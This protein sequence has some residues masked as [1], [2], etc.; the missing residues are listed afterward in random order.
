MKRF[1]GM[2]F[3]LAVAVIL[4]SCAQKAILPWTV[5]FPSGTDARFVPDE[6]TVVFRSSDVEVRFSP[7]PEIPR[8][9]E[10][11]EGT[12]AIFNGTDQDLIVRWE[13]VLLSDSYGFT[14][15]FR[16]GQKERI[17]VLFPEKDALVT[18]GSRISFVYRV[19]PADLVRASE[20]RDL[21]SYRFS[22]PLKVGG[23]EKVFEV[24]YQ[25]LP[26]EK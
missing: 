1:T 23:E 10:Y 2:C 3:I 18:P 13:K 24:D 6:R 16:F 12:I 11:Y 21:A 25:V 9:G 8:K 14:K 4:A 26:A 19:K 15:R 5:L 22:L 7:L 20:Y 17:P